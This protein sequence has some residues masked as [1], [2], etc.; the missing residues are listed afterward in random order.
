[1]SFRISQLLSL[2]LLV[3]LYGGVVANRAE[4]FPQKNDKKGMEEFDEVDPYTEG[5]REKMK[6]LGYISFGPFRWGYGDM[7]SEV[8]EKLGGTPM[9]FVETAHFKI[10]ST[11]TT[12]EIP[13]DSDEKKKLKEEF[14]RLKKRL[15]KLK[16]PRSKIDPW[17]RLHLIAQRAEEV[18]ESF[19]SDIGFDE[20]D[21]GKNAATFG[22]KE[23]FKVLLFQRKSEFGRYLKSYHKEEGAFAWRRGVPGDCM[24]F[25]ANH[26]DFFQRWTDPQDEPLDAMLH[27]QMIAG[28]VSNFLEGWREKNYVAPAW[29]SYALGHLY[30]RRV[31]PRWITAAGHRQDANRREGDW[32]WAKAVYSLVKNDFYVSTEDMFGWQKYEDMNSRD[33]MIAWSKLDYLMSQHQGDGRFEEF[34]TML[35]NKPV[36]SSN[37]RKKPKVAPE[38][39]EAKKAAELRQRQER[40]LAGAFGLTAA[41]LDE[42]WSAWVKKAY[43]KR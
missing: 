43:R 14:K 22:Q 7:T 18:Y 38:E 10:G 5:E 35:V 12:Y 41:E 20:A 11:L 4:A 13:P 3:S 16:A 42:A 32:K 39:A 29:M 6:A 34:F 40:A 25:A 28:L 21:F 27:C 33:H 15:G 24:V 31:D 9:I 19:R 17:L 36:N 30:V 1:M 2:V 37:R 8:A 23:K 26:E